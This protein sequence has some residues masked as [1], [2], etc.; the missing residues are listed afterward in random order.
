MTSPGQDATVA[1][2]GEAVRAAVL[3]LLINIHQKFLKVH[4]L[5]GMYKTANGFACRGTLTSSGLSLG[6]GVPAPSMATRQQTELGMVSL[7]LGILV[8]L[9]PDF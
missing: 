9:T 2:R 6:P 8:S 7:F 1:L 3:P 4:V 5:P